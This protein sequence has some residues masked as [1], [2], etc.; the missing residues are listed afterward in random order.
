MKRCGG[1]PEQSGLI[2]TV[3]TFEVRIL[4]LENSFSHGSGLVEMC[5]GKPHDT[6]NYFLAF[7]TLRG[8]MLSDDMELTMLSMSTLTGMT[9][10]P[11]GRLRVD[12]DLFLP[13]HSGEPT[14]SF[15]TTFACLDAAVLGALD[16][17]TGG[18]LTEVACVDCVETVASVA[19]LSLRSR[20]L[21]RW[22]CVS[23][24]DLN[25]LRLPSTP[26]LTTKKS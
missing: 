11:Y 26:E 5:S 20:L 18:G 22:P 3:S 1:E 14:G 10:A 19:L 8:T 17:A 21:A 6:S 13:F 23:T 24:P 15:W 4:I 25:M 2:W 16:N 12:P 7:V 9:G